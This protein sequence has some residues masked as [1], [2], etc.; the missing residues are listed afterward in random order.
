MNENI[1]MNSPVAMVN[2]SAFVTS[3]TWERTFLIFWESCQK[4]TSSHS[5]CGKPDAFPL[6]PGHLRRNQT[7]VEADTETERNWIHPWYCW[8]VKPNQSGRPTYLWTFYYQVTTV[9]FIIKAS[10]S[11]FS[12]LIIKHTLTD[13]IILLGNARI[14]GAEIESWRQVLQW[15]F[16]KK[17]KYIPP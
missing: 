11:S 1:W 9:P 6:T 12:L 3:G 7:A 15:Q 17:D 4:P 14:S 2:Y 13:Y 8:D 10:L 16:L 5:P